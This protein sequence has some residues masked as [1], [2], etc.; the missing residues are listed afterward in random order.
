MDFDGPYIQKLSSRENAPIML[1]LAG[2]LLYFSN[3]RKFIS[4][5][6]K[7]QIKFTTFPLN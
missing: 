1:L 2:R 3:C 5:N 4:G 7:K 6:N